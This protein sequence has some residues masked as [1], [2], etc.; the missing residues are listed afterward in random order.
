MGNIKFLFLALV[1]LIFI[2]CTKQ[3][4]SD[5]LTKKIDQEKQKNNQTVEKIQIKTNTYKLSKNELE[6]LDILKEDKY[7]SLCSQQDNYISILKMKN[8]FQ[9]SKALENLFLEYVNNLE[10]SCIDQISFNSVLKSSKFKKRKQHYKIYNNEINKEDILK[11]F[12]SNSIS[13]EKILSNYVPKHPG[14]FQLVEKL[15]IDKL[16]AKNYNKLR[17]NIERL[18]LLKDYDDEYFIK[19]NIPSHNFTLF[20]NGEVE[21][22]FGTVVGDKENQTPILSSE[23]SYFIINPQWNIPD[24]IAKNTIIPRA[25]KDKNYLRKK[26][27]V[28]RK[29]I[30]NIDAPKVSFN[31]INWKKYLKKNVKY[32]PY[33]FIQLPSR[34]NGMGKVKYMFKN[35]HAVY[36]HDTIGTWRFKDN[37]EKIRFASHGCVRLEHPISLMKHLTTY[38]TPQSY[39]KIRK[40]YLKGEMDTVNLSKKMPLHITYLTANVD[41]KGKLKFYKDVYEYDKIQKLNFIPHKNAIELASLKKEEDFTSF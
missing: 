11:K 28:I 39:K 2:S 35:D 18:K 24:S 10:N 5:N 38:Y 36:M 29:K 1:S 16:S 8:S 4:P 13:V 41:E 17:L 31:S 25:L 3:V 6:L 27:I 26:N 7:A 30:Y 33:K 20:E 15:D 12:N 9:K 22:T 23:L 40:T 14:F 37:R 19:L 32:I 34:A 21:R